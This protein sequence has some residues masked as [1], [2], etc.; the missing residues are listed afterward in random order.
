MQIVKPRQGITCFLCLK[1]NIVALPA[2]VVLIGLGEQMA[3]RFLPLYLMAF[4]PGAFSVGLLNGLD[5]L[6]SVLYSF[7][8]GYAS[9]KPG[10]ERALLLFNLTAMAAYVVVIAIPNW[11]AVILRAR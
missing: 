2:M 1:I 9:D 6:V 8:G 5:N 4:G 7:P 11:Q 3:K 10:Y